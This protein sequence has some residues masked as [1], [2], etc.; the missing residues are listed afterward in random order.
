M[1]E[2]DLTA[3]DVVCGD[4][5]SNIAMA[6]QQL[7]SGEEA[8]IILPIEYKESI[9]VYKEAL[10]MIGADVLEVKEENNKLILRVKKA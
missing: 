9:E 6:V 10:K 3:Q 7:G 2:I 4:M 5:I 8:K 1:K